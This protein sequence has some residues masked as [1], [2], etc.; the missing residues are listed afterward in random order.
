ML[1]RLTRCGLVIFIG[2]GASPIIGIGGFSGFSVIT[3][4][5]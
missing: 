5:L 2:A 4:V 3:L 1:S